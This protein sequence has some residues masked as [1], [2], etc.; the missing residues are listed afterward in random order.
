[1][2]IRVLLAD[3]Q[4]LLRATFRILIDAQSDFAVVAEAADGREAVDLAAAHR[5]DVILMD[6]RM[7]QLDGVAATAAI[8]ACPELSSS[9]ILVLTTFENDE[10]V[11]KALRAGASGFLGKDVTPDALLSGIRT[12]AA[13]DS[14]LS[15]GATR[16]LISRFLA[17]PHHEASTSVPDVMEVL[18]ER[19]REV[20]ALAAHG[21][22][23]VEIAE[24]LVVSPLTVRSHIQRAMN[25]LHA[26]DRAQLVVH[27]YRSGL[28][29]PPRRD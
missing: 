16:T 8:C 27:A 1:M 2:T 20:T 21:R 28:V 9:R 5:P 25:K 4:A 26:R 18:T 22:S 11:A 14:L 24:E 7:P 6:I 15:P 10:N 3:D 12:V 17:L 13:G 19:E 29:K 23:N